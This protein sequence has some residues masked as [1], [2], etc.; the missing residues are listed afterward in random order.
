[1]KRLSVIILVVFIL[2]LAV[3]FAS[4]YQQEVFPG[5]YS[6]EKD[7]DVLEVYRGLN[8]APDIFHI[9]PENSSMKLESLLLIHEIQSQQNLLFQIALVFQILALLIIKR[10]SIYPKSWS[11]VDGVILFRIG[12]SV[13]ILILLLLLYIYT[14]SAESINAFLEQLKTYGAEE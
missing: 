10:K 1:L 7:D 13:L 5:G 2:P 14:Q 8:E 12:A 3:I 9:D 11:D 6:Y 4:H